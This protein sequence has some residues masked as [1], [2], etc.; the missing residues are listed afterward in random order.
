M[1]NK[2]H[3]FELRFFRIFESKKKY[4]KTNQRNDAR[5]YL[6]ELFIVWLGL[7]WYGL[8]QFSF[9][10]HIYCVLCLVTT[11]LLLEVYSRGGL[12]GLIAPRSCSV[13]RSFQGFFEPNGY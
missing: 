9:I 11:T 10:V 2:K 4:L 6:K 7:V 12:W 13:N 1:Q 5:L 3:N 8:P